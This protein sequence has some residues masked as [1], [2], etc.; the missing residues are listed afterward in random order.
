MVAEDGRF[1]IVAHNGHLLSGSLQM[2]GD[3]FYGVG[4]DFAT[5]NIEYFSGPTTGLQVEGSLSERSV[6][7]GSWNTEWGFYGK[8]GF[9]YRQEL[10]EIRSSFDA[11]AGVWSSYHGDSIE[12]VWTVETD[13]RFNGQDDSGCLLSGYFA[14]IDERYSLVDVELTITDCE[15]A[16]TYSG[17]AYRQNLV[18]WWE[19]AIELSVDD[20]ERVLRIVLLK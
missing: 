11:L 18:D 9:E 13:G 19:A 1:R 12:G 17:L 6:F 3:T 7:A 4:V 14:L 2:N 16:S 10:Y 20:G 8:F 15:L 5:T